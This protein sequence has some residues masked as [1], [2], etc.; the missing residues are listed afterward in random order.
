[1]GRALELSGVACLAD[2]QLSSLSGGERQRSLIAAAI[3]QGTDILF[4]D[5][6]TS[7]LDYRHQVETLELIEMINREE[8][9]TILLV[10][11]DIN[12]AIHSASTVVAMKDG[13]LVWHGKRDELAEKNLLRDIFE[14][15]FEIFAAEG[16]AMLYVAPRGLML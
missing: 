5:E 16:R 8:K 15:D 3:A 6:P 10:T 13:R 1:V 11:H 7:F 14:T 4:L 12:L 2:R 9:M